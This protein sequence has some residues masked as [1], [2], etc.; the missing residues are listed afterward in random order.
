LTQ[1]R[2]LRLIDNPDLLASVSYEEMKTIALA[3]P[4]A[5]NLRYLLALKAQ[6]DNHPDAER[7]LATA[8]A[9][10]LDRFRL[11]QLIKLPQLAPQPAPAVLEDL[12]LELK[13]IEL[14]QQELQALSP[15][16]RTSVSAQPA[17]KEITQTAPVPSQPPP[18]SAPDLELQAPEPPK[19]V[20]HQP[21]ALWI[22]RFNPP[23]LE[24]EP[25]QKPAEM[26]AIPET[27][28]S[29]SVS[30]QQLAE[31]S[32]AENKDIISET[33]ARLLAKQGYRDKAIQM[34]ERLSLAFPEKSA[35]FAAEI[36]K[37]K[38]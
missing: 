34:Y 15:Q 30:A 7:T 36:E 21:F 17:E 25:M 13:P 8:A 16:P 35:Y 23:V 2:F 10:S 6:Q 22:A 11:L 27:A 37:L 18:V 9:Y 12:I 32:V 33:L 5:H 24:A 14:V 3:Y 26:P 4:Y 38:K 28:A 1:E 20:F 29:G 31:R 19:T